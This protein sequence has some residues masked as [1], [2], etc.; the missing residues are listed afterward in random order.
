[1][2][3]FNL[4]NVQLFLFIIGCIQ[5]PALWI[6]AQKAGLSRWGSFAAVVFGPLG[7]L[8]MLYYIATSKWN[9]PDR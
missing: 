3:A 6:I 7:L 5:V 8:A 1:M 2:P 9:D 4:H